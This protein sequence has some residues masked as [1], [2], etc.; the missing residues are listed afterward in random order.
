MAHDSMGT[1]ILAPLPLLLAMLSLAVSQAIPL[2]RREQS[3][4]GLVPVGGLL[5]NSP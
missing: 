3:T 4:I 5:G 2:C 1:G